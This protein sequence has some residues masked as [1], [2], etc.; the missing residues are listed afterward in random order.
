MRERTEK[1]KSGG[2]MGEGKERNNRY[3]EKKKQSREGN[4]NKKKRTNE[5]GERQETE[6]KR[7]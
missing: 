6:T 2:K 7:K 3:F 4:V 5:E 1:V